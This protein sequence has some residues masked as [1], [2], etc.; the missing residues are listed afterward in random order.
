MNKLSFQENI[1]A[2]V[3]KIDPN[4][5]LNRNFVYGYTD[6]SLMASLTYGNLAA[7][8]DTE[9]FITVFTKEKLALSKVS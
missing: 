5:E 2:L 8:I 3:T 7:A 4:I 9:Y 6:A 1:E